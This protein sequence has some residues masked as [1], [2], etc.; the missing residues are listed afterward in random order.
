MRKQLFFTNAFVIMIMFV[1]GQ[2][3]EIFQEGDI[4]VSAGLAHYFG[5]LNN[6]SSLNSAKPVLGLFARKQFGNYVALRLSGHY[7]NL[8]Y[9]DI[10]SNIDFQKV[11]NLSFNTDLWEVSLQGDFNFFRF[12]PGDASYPFTPYITMGVGT[13]N[14]NPYAFLNGNKYFLRELGTEGQGSTKY[15]E[16][17]QYGK[18]AFC[19]PLGMGVKFNI[20]KNVN[21]A[22]EFSYRFTNTDYLDDV[23]ST[24]AGE[25]T[26]VFGSPAYFLQDRSYVSGKRIGITGKQRGFSEQ[27][28]QYI[29]AEMAISFSFSSYRCANPK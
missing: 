2:M 1:H 13:F 9:S 16:R 12:V 3:N 28:D 20:I 5:D 4:G 21:F 19:I 26:F 22:L 6:Q 8:G 11:R 29:F 7:T 25:D 18:Q 17:K 14:Y 24:Y 23:S 27:K 10:Y 15:P